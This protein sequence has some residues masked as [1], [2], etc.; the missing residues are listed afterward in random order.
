MVVE[1]RSIRGEIHMI[2]GG[3]TRQAELLEVKRM[4]LEDE[5]EDAITFT[6]RDAKGVL[7]LHN[8]AVVVTV[9]IADFNVHHV[10]IDNRSLVDILYF[11]VFIQMGF[12][13]NQLS[14]F[15]TLI[16]NFFGGSMIPER[17]IRL[18]VIVGIASK[19]MTTQVNFLMVKLPS[20]YNAILGHPSLWTLKA[21]VSSYY[22]MVKFSTLNRVEQIRGNQECQKAISEEVDKL[23]KV[24]FIK[25]AMYPDWLANVVLI[26][27][28]N[29]KWHMCID[30]IDLNKTYPKNSYLLPRIDQMVDAITGVMPFGLKN[31]AVTYQ[32]L[33]DKIF[34]D[35]LDLNMKVYVDD[36][37]VNSRTIL[38]HI[39]DLQETFDTLH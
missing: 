14:R 8:D 26:K 37:L 24:G 4:R 3:S 16:Q 13:A 15:D 23:L 6:E 18:P 39:A 34:K 33:V 31:I 9:N 7:A 28:A 22:L 36:M 11:F 38:D 27:K 10:F 29:G 21:M 35:Q 25:E 17:M 12:T 5:H 2:T 32:R 19:W 20:V 30:F 1:D